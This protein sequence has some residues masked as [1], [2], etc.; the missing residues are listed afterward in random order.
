MGNFHGFSLK[1]EAICFGYSSVGLVLICEFNEAVSLGSLCISIRNN[2][3]R[4]NGG[5]L[6]FEELVDFGLAHSSIQIPYIDRDFLKFIK[7]ITPGVE[8]KLMLLGLTP[9][10]YEA[11]LSL[12]YLLGVLGII[13]P[14]NS[15]RN[16][17]AI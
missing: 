3:C 1:V 4:I 15:C 8:V 10:P 16:F 14:L 13:F 12:K 17:K 7:N 9:P 11:H 6:R 2:L 5:I